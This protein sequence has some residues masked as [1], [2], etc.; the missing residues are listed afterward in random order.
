VLQYGL[1]SSVVV[2][3]ENGMEISGSMKI[4]SS[5]TSWA[6]IRFWIWKKLQGVRLQIFKF[7]SVSYLHVKCWRTCKR[8]LTIAAFQI[9]WFNRYI[10]TERTVVYNEP[11]YVTIISDDE[12][13]NRQKIFCQLEGLVAITFDNNF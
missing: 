8:E 13:D 7:T 2:C 3:F 6:N 1:K 11:W 5:L 12:I 9:W 10:I 4:Q